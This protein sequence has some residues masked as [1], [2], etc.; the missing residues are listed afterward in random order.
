M[1]PPT[2]TP[3]AGLH[4]LLV[5]QCAVGGGGR[6]RSADPHVGG[7]AWSLKSWQASLYSGCAE[8]SRDPTLMSPGRG[9]SQP[10]LS[11]ETRLHLPPPDP[12]RQ[13]GEGK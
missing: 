6:R 1:A 4:R 13:L 8:G 7:E 11:L 9:F 3:W 12:F 2:L 10:Q 5:T